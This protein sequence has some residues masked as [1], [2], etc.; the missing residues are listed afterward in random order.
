VKGS[1]RK[2]AAR[3]TTSPGGE[4]GLCRTTSVVQQSLG[5]AHTDTRKQGKEEGKKRCL[6]LARAGLSSYL[7]RLCTMCVNLSILGV[8]S[9]PPQYI[10]LNTGT[11]ITC[12]ELVRDER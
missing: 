9:T 11:G 6:F 12:H 7:S 1:E 2:Q 10:T 3:A 4:G 8:V 5:R